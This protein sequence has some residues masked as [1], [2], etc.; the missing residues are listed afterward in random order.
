MDSDG[1]RDFPE[2]FARTRRFSLGV[3]RSFTVSPDGRRVL[4]L[5]TGGGSDPVSRLWLYEDGAERELAHPARLHGGTALPDAERARRERARELTDGIVA[6]A[7][8]AEVRTAVFALG[9]VLWVVRTGGRDA[10][11]RLP[12]AGPVVDPRLSPDGR[13]VAYVTRG[14]LHVADLDGNDR[15]IAAPDGPE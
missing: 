2:Q 3:P 11:L 12:A 9:G 7:A 14:A 10:P 8:D 1:V 4:F 6:Y 5:R 15:L 13:A